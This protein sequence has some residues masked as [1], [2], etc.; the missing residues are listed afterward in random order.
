ME[1]AELV[2]SGLYNMLKEA[3]K[4]CNHRSKADHDKARQQWKS[5]TTLHS[6]EVIDP[7]IDK[8]R[9]PMPR[10]DT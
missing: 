10:Y 2:L 7:S 5:D 8:A 6:P 9:D 1:Q 3:T 4:R